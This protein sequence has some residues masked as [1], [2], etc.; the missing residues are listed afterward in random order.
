MSYAEHGPR[1]FLAGRPNTGTPLIYGDYV[2]PRK[3]LE[4]RLKLH[5]SCSDI[6]AWSPNSLENSRYF[7]ELSEH[8]SLVGKIVPFNVVIDNII[9][10]N[11]QTQNELR[12]VKRELQNYK[13]LR[14]TPKQEEQLQHLDRYQKMKES[15]QS[16]HIMGTLLKDAFANVTKSIPVIN[17][18][19]YLSVRMPSEKH[20]QLL[21]KDKST[22]TNQTSQLYSYAVTA[23][24]INPSSNNVALVPSIR[25]T[26]KASP[27]GDYSK[28]PSSCIEYIDIALQVEQEMH[29]VG[30]QFDGQTDTYLN[31]ITTTSVVSQT[32]F[33]YKSSDEDN[34][35]EESDKSSLETNNQKEQ[36]FE[37]DASCSESLQD[38]ETPSESSSDIETESNFNIHGSNHKGIIIQKD[39]EI[40]VLKNELCVRDAELEEIRDINK[41]LETLLKEKEDCINGQQDNV[42]ASTQN[43]LHDKLK[44]LEH[45]RNCEVEDLKAKFYGC[46]YLVDQLKQDLNKKCESYYLQSQ[47]IEKLRPYV[48]EVTIL[49]LEKDSLLKKLQEMNRLTEQAEN[50]DLAL[51]R[52]KNV[53]RE[54]DELKKQ[55]YEQSRILAD[56]EEEIKRLLILIRETSI[57]HDEQVKTKTIL[58]N[59][60]AN[61]HDKTIKISQYEEQLI[62]MKQEISDFVNNLKHALNNLEEFHGSFEDVC[63]C[64]KC[65]LDINEEANTVLYN[66]NVLMTR[67]QS[68]KIERQNL[69][70]QI[71]DLKHYVKNDKQ[72]ACLSKN[73]KNIIFDGFYCESET[74]SKENTS[75][76]DNIILLNVRGN[77]NDASKSEIEDISNSDNSEH[78]SNEVI[79]NVNFCL[80]KKEYHNYVIKLNKKSNIDEVEKEIIEYISY[81]LIKIHSLIQKLQVYIEIERPLMIKQIYNFYEVLRNT[82]SAINTSQDISMRKQRIAE[83]YNQHKEEHKKYK[84]YNKQLPNNLFQIQIKINEFIETILY[85]LLNEVVYVE[86]QS[87]SDKQINQAFEIHLKSCI[88]RINVALQGAGDQR[89]QVVEEIEKQQK[90]LQKKDLEISQLKEEMA[91]LTQKGE[92]DCLNQEESKQSAAIKEELSN[93]AAEL[94]AKKAFISKLEEQLQIIRNELSVCEK[95]CN[96]LRKQKKTFDNDKNK[97]LK[98]CLQYKKQLEIKNTEFKILSQQHRDLIEAQNS[99]TIMEDKNIEMKKRLIDLDFENNELKKK[100]IQV[101]EILSQK[102]EILT[103]LKNKVNE[104]ENTL[105]QKITEHKN[106][107]EEKRY[108]ITKLK[109]ENRMLNTKLKNTESKLADT[110]QTI[111]SLTEQNDKIDIIYL[112]QE[113]LAKLDKNERKLKAELNNLKAQHANDQNKNKQLDNNLNALLYE[114]ENL[115]KNTE[116]LKNE[117][118]EWSI[119]LGSELFE[120]KLRNKLYTISNNLYERLLM[121]NKQFHPAKDLS[122]RPSNEKQNDKYTM[123]QNKRMEFA[124]HNIN[125]DLKPECGHAKRENEI[126]N[127][128]NPQHLCNTNTENE[129]LKDN[130]VISKQ[131]HSSENHSPE[132]KYK[133]NRLEN[134]TDE[135][136]NEIEKL[137]N[138]LE[139][140]DSE[141]SN[142]KDALSC[143][144]Q[145]K[146]DLHVELKSQIEEYQG[147]LTL[148][149]RN[150]DSSLNALCERH[151]ESVETLQKRFE[152]IINSEDIINIRAF[153]SENW[154]QS[155]NMNELADLYK[156]ICIIMNNSNLIRTKDENRCFY[157]ND[158]KSEFFKEINKTE[159]S[160]GTSHKNLCAKEESSSKFAS[161]ILK[162]QNNSYLQSQCQFIISSQIQKYPNI[163]MQD[164]ALN[165]EQDFRC[166]TDER[167][168]SESEN[169]YEKQK[170]AVK[171]NS[172]V[173][174]S[175]L[176]T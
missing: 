19:S 29:D 176:Q 113:E 71:E 43:I 135:N 159:K 89:L 75:G 130:Y 121:L 41:N 17:S 86:S 132:M 147:K 16:D 53:L 167:K 46:K 116:Y 54:N 96:A 44:K 83:L 108:E 148:M 30:V 11:S 146:V 52:L 74:N 143:L 164:Y 7:R 72:Q 42:K 70:Q 88:D 133:I 160:L 162:E 104:N 103:N 131:L 13:S 24:N 90:Q 110:N 26:L 168:P 92:G 138:E 145:E 87:M 48:K 124:L 165:L 174:L 155:L 4:G 64:T 105:S 107:M 99:R 139:I 68:Y 21:K 142:L 128:Q 76:K 77:K 28:N 59:L 9:Q 37:C 27:T 6:R 120:E 169:K 85:Q 115:K 1:I 118:A 172:T 5:D 102:D 136:R 157:E 10:F 40:I 141:I 93:V 62:S 91:H 47:E 106:G 144:A 171:D 66:I 161:S 173:S 109:D 67:F 125:D 63:I 51:E 55:N 101:N 154:L 95:D 15:L 84:S 3:R 34:S 8:D 163:Q 50:Y 111:L 56:Q 151:K 150:Y 129:I 60:K 57:T 117:N 32:S 149:K 152:D 49:R 18:N 23:F 78:L 79:D 112:L 31:R 80:L 127:V 58:E 140:R 61:I 81:S 12:A 170:H 97:L 2:L 20:F 38:I 25:S 119:K 156:R 35:A 36:S 14:L 153:D 45:Q 69:L 39:S 82:E 134:G 122:N 166:S 73:L 175:F 114:N 158:I 98:D 126:E 94:N 65:D 123:Y 137:L 33:V 100:V 22:I